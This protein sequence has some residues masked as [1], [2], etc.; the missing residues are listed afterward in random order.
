MGLIMFYQLGRSS[1]AQTA[2][3]LLEKSRVAGWQVMVR[4]TD[5]SAL[6]ALDQALWHGPIDS[7][8]PHG[9]DTQPNANLQS[10]LLGSGAAPQ[11]YDALMLID[12]AAFST[13]EV[14]RMKRVMILFDGQNE[15]ILNQARMQW[16]EVA[17]LGQEAQFWS[18]A[19][20]IWALQQSRPAD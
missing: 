10:I 6:E 17:T 16:K 2:R 4:G 7:F 13:S 15:A 18:E 9:L 20:G 12:G 19:S 14:E 8:L 3:A 5:Q 11:E 1:T